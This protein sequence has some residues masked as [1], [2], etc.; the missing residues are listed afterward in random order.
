VISS[1]KDAVQ[2]PMIVGGGLN[3]AEKVREAFAAG[4]DL[5]VLGNSIEKDPG[6]LAEV[7]NIKRWY[8]ISLNIN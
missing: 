1:V 3:N 2:S 4:A 6:F 7:L 8:N 5:V